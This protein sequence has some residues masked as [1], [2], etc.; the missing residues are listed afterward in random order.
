[1]RNRILALALLAALPAV[2]T[3]L[4]TADVRTTEHAYDG[5]IT[6]TGTVS[7]FRMTGGHITIEFQNRASDGLYRNGFEVTP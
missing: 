4:R 6:R 3:T 1:M 5:T 2:A 7:A